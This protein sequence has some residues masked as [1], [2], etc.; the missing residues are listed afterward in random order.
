VYPDVVLSESFPV[1]TVSRPDH[2][3]SEPQHG[4]RIPA[5]VAF[6]IQG[7][8]ANWSSNGA[9]RFDSPR[10]GSIEFREVPEGIS[11]S[12]ILAHPGCL[13]R[14]TVGNQ[15]RMEKGT[16]SGVIGAQAPPVEVDS[17]AP[18]KAHF[19]MHGGPGL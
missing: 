17:A 19:T 18:C 10:F 9:I 14:V 5:A 6:I 3:P 2:E 16:F 13:A 8:G 4:V 1:G 15:T 7:P 12:A 11:Y